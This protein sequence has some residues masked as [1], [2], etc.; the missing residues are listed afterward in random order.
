MNL[1]QT[2]VRVPDELFREVKILAIR[3]GIQ[4]QE[5]FTRALQDYLAK[6]SG[7]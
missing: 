6:P 1:V 7:E 3:Q 2:G 4:L 5:L